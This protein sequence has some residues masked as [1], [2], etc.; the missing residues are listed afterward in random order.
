M[1]LFF[2]L[3][4]VP[5]ACVLGVFAVAN[6]DAVTLTFW[7]LPVTLQAPI[8]LIVLLALLAGFL[9]GELVAWINGHHWRREA[10]RL[11]RR[12]DDAERA[13]AAHAAPL[14]SRTPATGAPSPSM[15]MAGSPPSAPSREIARN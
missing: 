1:K 7:P 13:L 14:G 3:V 8:Y 12:V 11:A 2:W 9:I 10:R 4:I 5:I 15:E 6:R